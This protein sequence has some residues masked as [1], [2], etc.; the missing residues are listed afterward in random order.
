MKKLTKTLLAATITSTLSM[1]S[2]VKAESIDF[3]SMPYGDKILWGDAWETLK[4]GFKEESGIDVNHETIAWG[5]AFQ[6]YLT[7]AQGGTHP[8][9]AD[10][11][12]LHSFSAIGGDKFGPMPI[13][14]YRDQFPDLE[15]DFYAGALKDVFWQDDFYGIPWRGDIR[16]TLY[17]TD[18]F[19][20]VGIANPPTTWDETIETAKALTLRD[21]DGNVTRWGYAF[22]TSGKPVDW[23]LPLYWQAGGEM[24]TEDG[25]TATLDNDAMRETLTFMRDMLHV[26]KVADVD[27]FEKG[28]ETRN[29]FADGQI[30]LIG[31]AHQN[32]GKRF[33]EEFAH[34]E[35]KWAFAR[36][37]SGPQDADSFSG[38]GYF[39][40]LRGTEK[41][42]ECVAF[43]KYLS[44]DENISIL[45]EASGNVATKPAVMAS[46]FWSD[47]PWKIKVG[48]ALQDA[49][50]SQ[51]PAPA[52][53]SIAT[54]EP[55]GIIFDLLY[56]SVVLQND[57]DEEIAKAQELMQAEISR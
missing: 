37:A 45:S 12:W 29:L 19:E 23:L 53:S 4:A 40:V 9:C 33:D 22:G 41:V 46:E 6:T 32:W 1:G 2:A 8:D 3:W 31:S 50:T 27:S 5:S 10:M 13:N 51:H 56:N 11:Y 15:N 49:H 25:L 30:A 36:S 17:R 26:H 7:I 24:M 48:E 28:Y 21:A 42:E 52:W 57:M 55:G 18:V 16:S 38:A 44:K 35:G 20:E 34:L 54:S 14:E 39:G 43:L 47:R